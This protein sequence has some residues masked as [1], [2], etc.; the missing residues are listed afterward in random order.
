MR[1]PEC[2]VI[3]MTMDDVAEVQALVT[4]YAWAVD[5][6][7]PDAVVACFAPGARMRFVSTGVVVEGHEA[8][9]SFF[10]SA[11]GAPTATRASTHLMGNMSVVPRSADRVEARTAAVVYH[12]DGDA[13]SIAV[14]GI[15][16]TDVCVR[17]AE[18]YLFEER[19]HHLRWTGTLPGGTTTAEPG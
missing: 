4:R 3:N 13:A 9:R 18:G 15:T 7:D 14:R 2:M 16:Y 1:L 8:I 19:E 11:L 5:D 12:V 10:A 17:T 6:L